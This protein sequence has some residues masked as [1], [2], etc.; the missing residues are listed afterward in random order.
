MNPVC[1]RWTDQEK[2]QG[3]S[4]S[5]MVVWLL[6]ITGAIKG[7][8][9]SSYKTYLSFSL[10]F[11]TNGKELYLM[12]KK[13]GQDERDESLRVKMLKTQMCSTLRCQ[14]SNC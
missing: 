13:Q 10:T 2:E 12:V 1:R 6:P 4:F 5:D 11:E 3:T 14:N 8:G 9:E 7:R